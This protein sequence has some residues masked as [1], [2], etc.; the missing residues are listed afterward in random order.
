M[1]NTI[2]ITLG[3]W[4]LP[5]VAPTILCLFLA[6]LFDDAFTRDLRHSFLV[7][8]LFVFACSLLTRYL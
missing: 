5:A 6:Y 7:V 8:A 4:M 3:F 2:T 1:S